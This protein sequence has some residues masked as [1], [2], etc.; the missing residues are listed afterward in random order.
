MLGNDKTWQ[1][2]KYDLMEINNN[3]INDKFEFLNEMQADAQKV[4]S[5]AGHV[6]SWRDY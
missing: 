5:D 6:R 3:Q 1:W 2:G 4:N